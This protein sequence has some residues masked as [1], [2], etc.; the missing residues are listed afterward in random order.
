MLPS[1]RLKASPFVE[2]SR[3]T[4]RTLGNVGSKHRMVTWP[5][6][7]RDGVQQFGIRTAL[8]VRIRIGFKSSLLHKL[9]EIAKIV[10]CER[11]QVSI[12]VQ[13]GVLLQGFLEIF[14]M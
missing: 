8:T 12:I 5:L 7:D 10:V 1:F 11:G 4:R 14:M 2:K 9:D 13:V 6:L 3:D